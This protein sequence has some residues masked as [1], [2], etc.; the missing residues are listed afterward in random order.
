MI[1]K[2]EC[3]GKWSLGNTAW[4]SRLAVTEA[5]T[6]TAGLVG[7]RI[8]VDALAHKFVFCLV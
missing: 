7:L 1:S 6:E 2:F 5:A 3:P 4:K 8:L